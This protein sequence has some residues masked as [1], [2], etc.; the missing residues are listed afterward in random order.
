MERRIAVKTAK[1]ESKNNGAKK[2]IAAS[3][4]YTITWRMD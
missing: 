4:N 2:D 3:R 1:D